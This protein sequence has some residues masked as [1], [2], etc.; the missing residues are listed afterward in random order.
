MGSSTNEINWTPRTILTPQAA[1]AITYGDGLYVYA[2]TGGMLNTLLT[3][4]TD[5]YDNGY[6]K[7]LDTNK[8]LGGTW[9]IINSA[10]TGSDYTVY[11]M[12]Y[13]N[14][15]FVYVGRD[16]TLTQARV[17][18]VR[19]SNYLDPLASF[20]YFGAADSKGFEN[21]DDDIIDTKRFRV[22]RLML[23]D[24]FK[25]THTPHHKE[26]FSGSLYINNEAE[27]NF[28][29]IVEFANKVLQSHL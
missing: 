17:A 4:T 19:K 7:R 1:Y 21:P 15:T 8:P 26:S 10:D 3:S 9:E 28:P 2:G 12:A 27:N 22:Y 18:A 20:G 16:E 6:N 25:N 29:G 24:R 23:D 14:G 13:G 11:G 5:Q